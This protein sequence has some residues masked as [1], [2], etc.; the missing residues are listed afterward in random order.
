MLE[1]ELFIDKRLNL[2][3]S[4]KKSYGDFMK[5][6]LPPLKSLRVFES[7][8]RWLSFTKAAEEL[9]LTQSA[10]S[11]Q[12][13]LLEDYFKTPLFTRNNNQ[14]KLSDKGQFFLLSVK[15]SLDII[16]TSS[17]KIVAPEHKPHLHIAAPPTFMQRWLLPHIKQFYVL[18]PDVNLF[19]STI[20]DYHQLEK[21]L[22]KF[23]AI[24]YYG[25]GRLKNIQSTPLLSEE[26]IS[27][28][29]ADILKNRPAQA[30]DL[31]Q[32]SLI[33][34]ARE[35]RAYLLWERWLKAARIDLFSTKGGL[36][37][38]S[39]EAMILATLQGY[40]FSIVDK[41]MVLNE[42]K[43]ETLIQW[44]PAKI[45]LPLGYWLAK[46]EEGNSST[47][48]NHFCDF[49]MHSHDHT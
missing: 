17:Q 19:F 6:K 42:L 8:A 40:G 44:H 22:Q 49:L 36:W 3:Y 16:E 31:A 9:N 23:D 15:S 11:K 38:D 33:H 39:F 27:V 7:A 13:K 14:L 25:D 35:S 18:H 26:L 46:N 45:S 30:V 12:I 48:L 43:N 47:L 20:Y 41:N 21:K 32:E 29:S 28:C 1:K 34:L 5:R 2:I 4:M 37:F 10:V 24:I